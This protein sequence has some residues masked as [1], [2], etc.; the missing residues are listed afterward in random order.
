MS[1][2][3]V[4]VSLI[5]VSA[6]LYAA[7]YLTAAVWS[8]SIASYSSDLFRAM[9]NYTGPHLRTW[10][11]IALIAGIAYLVWGEVSERKSR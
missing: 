10:S 1:R 7:R 6:I 4:G 8:S 9:L 11:V 2:R 5:G 3:A